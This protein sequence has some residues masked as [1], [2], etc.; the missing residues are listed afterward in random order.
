MD[1]FSF[2]GVKDSICE[3][4]MY[5]NGITEKA[6][7]CGC[8]VK[9]QFRQNY[10][11][12]ICEYRK[13]SY[14]DLSE[15][16]RRKYDEIK[17]EGVVAAKKSDAFALKLVRDFVR[18]K[19]GGDVDRLLD[20]DFHTLFHDGYS[21]DKYASC[22]GYA[23]S[24][25][26][27]VIVRAI[28]SLMFGQAWNDFS[29]YDIEKG[30]FAIEYFNPFFI[31]FGSP[32][33]IEWGEKIFKGL[34]RHNPSDAL[35][36][37]VFRFY[38]LYYSVGNMILLPSMLSRD[39]VEINLSRAKRRWREYPDEFLIEIFDEFVKSNHNNVYLKAEHFNNKAL[40]A[41]CSTTE[42]FAATIDALCLGDYVNDNSVPKEVFHTKCSFDRSPDQQTYLRGVNEFL[43]FCEE[44]I[45]KRA[46]EIVN[47]LKRILNDSQ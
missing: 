31:L 32:I 14:D 36:E 46:G 45:P 6:D 35:R 4:C 18:E 43:D 47:R 10:V 9:E 13:T 5:A 25:E 12:G 26:K 42:G 37:R 33:G 21:E 22:S 39:F 24:P 2:K 19:L 16:E 28:A 41:S 1:T 44:V 7:R 17:K 15:A 29:F 34:D 30:K 27:T 38:H 8:L 23:F 3:G 11:K 40:Y 20:F